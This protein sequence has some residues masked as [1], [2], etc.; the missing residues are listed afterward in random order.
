MPRL[1]LM[2]GPSGS[3]KTTEAKQML[4][5]LSNA[6]R[7]NRDELRLMSLHKWKGAHEKLIIKSEVAMA[8]EAGKLGYHIIVDDTNLTDENQKLWKNVA[9]EL[10]YVLEKRV[11]KT[12][13]EVCVARDDKRKDHKH[14]G[15]HAIERQFLR[16]KLVNWE[17]RRIRIW[18]ID[19]TIADLTHR[20]PYITIGADC[21]TCNGLKGYVCAATPFCDN[22]KIVEKDYARF[23]GSCWKDQPI[24]FVIEW[25]QA[26]AK[27]PVNMNILV[28]GR[29]PE[30]NT[31]EMTLNWL[32]WHGV[33]FEHIYMRRPYCHGLD[34]IEKQLILD[35]LLESG[36]KKEQIDFVVDDRPS[37]VAMWRANGL[38]VI[39]VRGRDDDAFYSEMDKFETEHPASL[40]KAE[41][42]MADSS[43]ATEP[44]GAI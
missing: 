21:P 13:L 7:L 20:V 38:R 18:D 42:K 9:N 17:G 41:G 6:V 14:I 5:N 3:G 44:A 31:A 30:N 12:P 19:G 36:L 10:G 2:V 25:M 33:P 37:V 23:Y 32:S 28:S 8:R 16:G 1:F 39:P 35:D 22:G 11:M 29:S 27:D 43:S 40:G 34:T 26:E 24:K 4:A 15:R